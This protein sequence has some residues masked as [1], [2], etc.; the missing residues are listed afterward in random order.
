MNVK[1]RM[2]S[3]MLVSGP[4]NVG[5]SVFVMKL[6]EH[7]QD[8][9]DIPPQQVFWCYSHKTATH[10]LMTKKGFHMI[11]GIPSNFDF[12]TPN[13]VIVLDDLMIESKNKDSVNLLFTAKAHHVPCFVINIQ[14]NLFY[15]GQGRDRHLNTQY[16]V[17]FQNNRD[18]LQIQTISRQM[19]PSTN[20]FMVAAFQ[21]ATKTPHSYLLV[22]MHTKT[23]QMLALRAR[24]LPDERPMVTYI[25]KQTFGDLAISSIKTSNV[26]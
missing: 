8:I 11:K 4:T 9:F 3:A 16:L 26:L 22:D 15:R 12:V 25:D 21:D 5:K 6:L 14:Q 1:L 10:D 2:G 7:S 19:F 17:L 23:P 20:N 13:S 18:K 24:I